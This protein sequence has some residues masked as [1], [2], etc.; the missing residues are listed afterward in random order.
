MFASTIYKS[1]PIRKWT[2]DKKIHF[3]EGVMQ[4]GHNYG[5]EY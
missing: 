2:K 1:K 5:D 3:I 4:M